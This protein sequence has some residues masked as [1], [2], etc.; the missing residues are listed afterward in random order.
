MVFQLC[1]EAFPFLVIGCHWVDVS[2][3]SKF[4]FFYVHVVRRAMLLL[5]FMFLRGASFSTLLFFISIFLGNIL[6]FLSR[7]EPGLGHLVRDKGKDIL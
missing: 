6:S 5:F 7:T 2:S 4:K 3:K 1:F